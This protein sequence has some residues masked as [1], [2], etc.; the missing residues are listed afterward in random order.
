MS[1]IIED[2]ETQSLAEALAKIVGKPVPDAIKHALTAQLE[3]ERQPSP[4]VVRGRLRAIRERVKTYP[5]LDPRSPDELLGY[6]ENGL[7]R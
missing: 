6:D 4:E 2:P 7:P 5:V 3:Q 1:L